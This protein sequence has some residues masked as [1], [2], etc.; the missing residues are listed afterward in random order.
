M[1]AGQLP[2]EVLGALAERPSGYRPDIEGLRAIAVLLVVAY[3]VRLPGIDAGFMGVDVFFVLS[4]YLITG[5][6]TKEISRTGTVSIAGF[7]A[8]R[9]RRLLP[10]ATLML[11]AALVAATLMIAPLALVSITRTAIATS[12]YLSNAWFMS[13]ESD[14]FAAG[15]ASDPFLHTWSLAVEEQFY[16]IW[17]LLLLIAMRLLR[18]HKNLALFCSEPSRASPF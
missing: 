14:Y 10:G 1:G 11:V 2:R 13:R 5:L 18:S 16:L 15:S 4:G 7:Y 6:L 9:V 3:H 8:R 12:L 17:P